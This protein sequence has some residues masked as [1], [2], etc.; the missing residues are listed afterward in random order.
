TFF[1]DHSRYGS[2]EAMMRL[3]T[4]WKV[5]RILDV[6]GGRSPFADRLVERWE[7]DAST[8][9]F[10][11]SSANFV[12]RFRADGLER[13]LRFADSSERTREMVEAEVDLL[14]WLGGGGVFVVRP[15]RSRSGYLV[16]TVDTDL[17]TFHAVVFDGLLGIHL[18]MGDLDEHRFVD[19]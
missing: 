9:R 11:R 14:E 3:S 16:E 17:G 2:A 4:L 7:N 15:V 13:Y 12:Y 8:L 10:V 6:A 5:D 1:A 19:W 18:E